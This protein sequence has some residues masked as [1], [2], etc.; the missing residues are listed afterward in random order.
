MAK[1]ASV[2]LSEPVS[3]EI[4]GIDDIEILSE[5]ETLGIDIP[6]PI[7]PPAILHHEDITN[8][9][10]FEEVKDVLDHLL[11]GNIPSVD[12]L[13]ESAEIDVDETGQ[14]TLATTLQLIAKQEKRSKIL[15]FIIRE[16]DAWI[17][18][19]FI[20]EISYLVAIV[21]TNLLPSVTSMPMYHLYV[22][23]FAIFACIASGFYNIPKLV[24]SRYRLV[25]VQILL[26]NIDDYNNNATIFNISV[27]GMQLNLVG[28]GLILPVGQL[29]PT[30]IYF[31][32]QSSFLY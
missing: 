30:N 22:F 16:L 31:Y 20:I 29:H 2:E 8:E 11:P 25:V 4:A 13:E 19:G 32:Q 3:A 24:P 15:S 5:G 18:Q 12:N 28:D 27:Y 6:I 17:K 1:S 23:R 21:L 26:G 7:Q 10:D 9:A 14:E